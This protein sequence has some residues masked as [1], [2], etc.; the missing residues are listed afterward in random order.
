MA[1]NPN[2]NFLR[3]LEA[4]E[5]LSIPWAI[6]IGKTELDNGVVILRDVPSR[7]VVEV[8]RANLVETLR[9]KLGC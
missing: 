2:W 7:E 3:Q 4:C 8:A 6:V 1:Y 9:E 5:K